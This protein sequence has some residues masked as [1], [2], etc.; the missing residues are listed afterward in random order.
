VIEVPPPWY[1]LH[2]HDI[3][4]YCNTYWGVRLSSTNRNDESGAFLVDRGFGHVV[5]TQYSKQ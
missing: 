2:Q 4:R 1:D 5:E 3:A